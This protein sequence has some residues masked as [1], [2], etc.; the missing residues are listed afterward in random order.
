M[1]IPTN[2]EMGQASRTNGAAPA[3]NATGTNRTIARTRNMAKRKNGS[4]VKQ[5]KT[6][7]MS[8]VTI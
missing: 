8:R 3:P 6:M 5:M 1:M 2:T 7:M 4:A